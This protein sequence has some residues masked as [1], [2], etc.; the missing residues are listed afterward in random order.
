M[1][2]NN[3]EFWGTQWYRARDSGKHVYFSR[4]KY[5][6]CRQRKEGIIGKMKSL[7]RHALESAGI[8]LET[9]PQIPETVDTGAPFYS[10]IL[11][12]VQ[13]QHTGVALTLHT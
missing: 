7:Y 6:L 5:V 11:W 13:C 9:V 12:N 4:G 1:L 8:P 3:Q 2:R 10:A